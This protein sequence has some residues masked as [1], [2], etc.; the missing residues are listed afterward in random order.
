MTSLNF[1]PAVIAAISLCLPSLACSA[2][3]HPTPKID[4]EVVWTEIYEGKTDIFSL[5]SNPNDF[6]VYVGKCGSGR[7]QQ[8]SKTIFGDGLYCSRKEDFTLLPAK[9]KRLFQ[10]ERG[11][12]LEPGL[13]HF[14]VKNSS[15]IDPKSKLPWNYVVTG[16]RE[17]EFVIQ[18]GDTVK[19]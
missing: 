5:V 9:S 16:E 11:C 15:A 17:F 3:E 8:N 14:R 10:L 7:F 18:N 12:K 1:V 4:V 13:N 2:H 6:D 19:R